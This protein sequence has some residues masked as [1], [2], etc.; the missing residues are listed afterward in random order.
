V[1]DIASGEHLQELRGHSG[2]VL[3]VQFDAAKILTISADNTMRQWAWE[4]NKAGAV[5]KW[6]T[7]DIPRENLTKIA[8]KYDV[9]VSDLMEWNGIKDTKTLYSGMQIIVA[10]AKNTDLVKEGDKKRKDKEG[11]GGGGAEGGGSRRRSRRRSRLWR[12]QRAS[13][14]SGRR[15]TRRTSDV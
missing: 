12:R 6:H 14:C 15:K 4:G 7:L 10:K 13:R 3:G 11:K 1:T 9:K 8:R 2:P 5:E